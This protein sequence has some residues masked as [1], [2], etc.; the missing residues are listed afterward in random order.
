MSSDESDAATGLAH[1][2]GLPVA[3]TRIELE[4]AQMTVTFAA[5]Q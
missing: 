3:E 4:T 2:R 1:L 5:K